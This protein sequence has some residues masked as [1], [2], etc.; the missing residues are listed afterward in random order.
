M[1]AEDSDDDVPVTR[2]RRTTPHIPVSSEE[3]AVLDS[4]GFT[5]ADIENNTKIP[6]PVAPL[7]QYQ[8]RRTLDWRSRIKR[9]IKHG[10][11]IQA[12]IAFIVGESVENPCNRCS[13]ELGA[14]T[15]CTV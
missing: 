13:K 3:D 8:E 15:Q 14:F 10:F 2:R 4:Q 9:N 6:A 1:D 11:N 12:A 5:L 7:L